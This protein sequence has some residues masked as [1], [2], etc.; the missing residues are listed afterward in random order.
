MRFNHFDLT[1]TVIDGGMAHDL[2]VGINWFLNPNM[3]I[4]LNYDYRACKSPQRLPN[5][6]VQGVGVRCA[7]DF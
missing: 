6:L 3:K 7:Y 4:Q 2:E 1:N 5:G